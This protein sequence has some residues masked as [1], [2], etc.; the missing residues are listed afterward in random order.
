MATP[1]V[2]NNAPI[3]IVTVESPAPDTAVDGVSNIMS[4][5]PTT[6]TKL[7]EGL[8][9][10]ANSVITSKRADRRPASGI[11]HKDQIRAAV[12]AAAVTV[13]LGLLLIG[14]I[15]GLLTARAGE[16]ARKNH[17]VT[18]FRRVGPRATTRT[19]TLPIEANQHLTSNPGK[20]LPPQVFGRCFQP[21][22]TPDANSEVAAARRM[23]LVREVRFPT[24][25]QRETVRTA[26]LI[27]RG[28]GEWC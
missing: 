17:E 21:T 10:D 25:E 4:L 18:G 3:I 14:L 20:S 26:R 28:A 16:V 23:A 12:V 7:Q 5:V 27:P 13:G 1:D 9:L 6:L 15:D 8:G 11:S 22:A 24:V 19:T 2:M